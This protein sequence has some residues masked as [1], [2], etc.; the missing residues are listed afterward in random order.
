V[1]IVNCALAE[2]Y[3]PGENPL[4]RRLQVLNGDPFTIALGLAG[5]LAATRLMASLL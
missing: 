5:T 2:R 3:F 4:G 1:V